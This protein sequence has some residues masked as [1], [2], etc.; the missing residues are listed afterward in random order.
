MKYVI[1]YQIPLN[2]EVPSFIFSGV[3]GIANVYKS[4]GYCVGISVDN[5]VGDFY[6]FS[7]EA[8][9]KTYI[10]AAMPLLNTE[11]CTEILSG[12]LFPVAPIGAT[13][14]WNKVK[15][16]NGENT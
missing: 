10:L 11:D 7:N 13:L 16:L 8:E 12:T 6:K 2:N 3:D 9:L 4:N 14:I 15:Y 5:A 1:K